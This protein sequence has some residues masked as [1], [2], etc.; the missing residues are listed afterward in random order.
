MSRGFALWWERRW[1]W[2]PAAIF[3]ALGI[4][5]LAGYQLAVAGRLGLQAGA[6]DSRKKE[7]DETSAR[8]RETEALVQRARTTRAAIDELYDKRLGSEAAR[9]T[10]VMLE[11]KHLARQAGLYGIEAINYGDEEVR[12]LPLIKKS[13]T[14][15]AAGSYAQLRAFINLLELS[16]SFMS[17]DEIRVQGGDPGGRLRLQVRLSTMFLDPEAGREP[18]PLPTAGGKA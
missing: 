7:L 1:V 9:L 16:P 4:G 10:A 5:L 17:L 11:V 14:F 18:R 13:I 3:V 12:E 2:L 8:R 6:L 15:S